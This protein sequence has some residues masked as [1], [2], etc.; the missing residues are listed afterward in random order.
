MQLTP[1]EWTLIV[2]IAGLLISAIIFLIG[3][4]LGFFKKDISKVQDDIANEKEKRENDDINIGKTLKEI[5][6]ALN[7]HQIADAERITDFLPRK[8]FYIEFTKT[9]KTLEKIHDRMDDMIKCVQD[10]DA[11]H[12]AKFVRREECDIKHGGN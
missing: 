3:Q 12:D 1:F 9:D 6:T 4:V 2:T 11:K 5:T 8:E 7:Q 10:I